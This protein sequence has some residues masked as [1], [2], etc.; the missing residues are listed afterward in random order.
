MDKSPFWKRVISD[1][2]IKQQAGYQIQQLNDP[3]NELQ[4]LTLS[5][6]TS[7]V[8]IEYDPDKLEPKPAGPDSWTRFVCISDTHSKTFD[9]PE[10]DVLLHSGDLTRTGKLEDFEKTLEWLYELPHKVK[11]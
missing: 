5:S 4:P 7:R 9:V 11:M 3:I 8:H 10:G 6:P 2:R 1:H